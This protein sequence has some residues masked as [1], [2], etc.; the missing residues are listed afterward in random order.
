MVRFLLTL[1]LCFVALPTFADPAPEGE[2][3][4]IQST[5]L[6]RAHLERS[7]QLAEAGQREAA[8]EELEKVLQ[9]TSRIPSAHY[10]RAELLAKQGNTAAAIDAYI[11]AIEAIALERYLR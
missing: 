10:Q 8:G 2:E 11:R 3:P 9:L 7:R 4:A 6:V 1:A 5:S